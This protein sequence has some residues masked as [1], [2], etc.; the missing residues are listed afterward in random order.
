[1][2]VIEFM[3]ILMCVQVL[4]MPLGIMNKWY[5]KA[6]RNQVGCFMELGGGWISS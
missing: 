3:S 1:M 2:K 5:G 6:I 4:K